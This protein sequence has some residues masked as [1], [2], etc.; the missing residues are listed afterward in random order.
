MVGKKPTIENKV[1]RTI[2]NVANSSI[3]AGSTTWEVLK[4]TPLI[5]VENDETLKSEGENVT[6]YI[7]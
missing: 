3:L 5:S 7:K 4:M 2:F 1:D 6:V